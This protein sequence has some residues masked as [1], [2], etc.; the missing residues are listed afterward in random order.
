[1]P[2]QNP[3]TEPP[4]SAVNIPYLFRFLKPYWFLVV[5][6]F[7]FMVGARVTGALD[8]IWLKNIIDGVTEKK[9]F[10]ALIPIV[11]TYFALKFGTSFLDYLRDVTFAPAQMGISRTLS[12]QLFSHLVK[13]PIAYHVDQKIG[14]LARKIT[15]GSRAVTFILD[16]TVMNILPTIIGLVI[17]AFFLITLYPPIYTIIILGTVIFY[18]W[19][20][21]W[22]T[23]KR[24]KYRLGSNL[25]DDEVAS[26]E[27]DALTNIETVKYFNNENLMEGRYL[28]AINERYKLTLKSNRLFALIAWGQGGIVLLGLGIVLF[29]GIR[30]A[31]AGTMTVGDLVL[32]ST[33]VIQLSAPIEVLGWIYREIKDG[34]IDLDGMAK[35]LQ[36]ENT[37]L[38][39]EHPQKI[40]ELKG[41]VSFESV[42]FSYAGRKDVLKDISLHVKPGHKVAFVGPSGAG[43]STIVKLLFRL[44][45]PTG[46]DISIDGVSL[47]DLSKEDRRDIFAIVPQEPVLFNASIAENIRFGKPDATLKEIKHAAQLASIDHIIEK[48][49]EKYDTIVGERGV[50]LSGGEKQRVAIA[51]A[52]I[53]DPKILVFDEAT[54]SLDTHSE[55]EIQQALDSVSKGRTTLAV[56]HRLSTIA[57]SDTIFVLDKGAIAEQGKHSE[58]LAKNGLYAKLWKLQAS[59]KDPELQ[60]VEE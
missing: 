3:N 18:A 9:D 13:L 54:S 5:L 53:K 41:E 47:K 7:I 36:V 50:K 33:Y 11:L 24:Q 48:F 52:V 27:V 46:G 58:L 22:S 14:G 25:A 28:P 30:E 45:E 34:L 16:F 6:T 35:V 4:F 44:F 31:A 40:K 51:R 12:H 23:Q 8:P 21:I 39:P 20:T 49:P 2:E 56:A 1:M 57:D 17:T 59:G 43:K 29:L 37:I 19:F 42:A 32:L 38:E 55:R 15:R 26:V 60:A 10:A